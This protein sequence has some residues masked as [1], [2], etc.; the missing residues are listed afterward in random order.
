MGI[1]S[2]RRLSEEV[3]LTLSYRW[4]RR[5]DLN[6][7]VPDHSTLSNN[8]HGRFRDSDRLRKLFQTTVERCMAEGLVGAEGPSTGS[9]HHSRS[10]PA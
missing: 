4:F 7:S 2:E 9:G 5:L 6:G 10:I 1:W 8:R 3:R